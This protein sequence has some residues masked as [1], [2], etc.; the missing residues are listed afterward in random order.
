MQK[1]LQS[2]EALKNLTMD[3]SSFNLQDYLNIEEKFSLS[4]L[5]T[6]VETVIIRLGGSMLPKGEFY[7]IITP[8]ALTNFP[9]V[10]AKYDLISFDRE[11]T[12]R[13]RQAELMGIGHPLIDAI[14]EYYQQVTVPGDI[15]I[16]SK[17]EREKEEYAVINTLFTIE[18]EGGSQ[19][20]ELKTFR[21]DNI[22]DV[23]IL[24]EEWLLE[25]LEKRD[26]KVETKKHISLDWQ[27]IK[28]NYDGA[29][30]A[31]LSQIKS[32]LENPVGARVR[33]LGIAAIC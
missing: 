33:L 25:R 1:A 23:K 32:S 31:I 18:L 11:L 14:I 30:G 6:L 22:G 8:K 12:M 7:S 21:I 27:R 4:N 17:A 3:L 13:K 28:L 15:T 26:F 5:K 29:V 19:H 10:A 9:K 24:P 2:I 20:R 16:L